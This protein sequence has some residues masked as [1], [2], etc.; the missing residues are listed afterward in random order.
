MT[1]REQ[2]EELERKTLSSFATLA[3]ETKG[4]V[5]PDEPCPI[6]TDFQRDRD[7]IIHCKSFRRLKHKTQV[8]LS[9]EGDHYRTRL[10]HTLEVSQIARTSARALRLNE[11][12]TEAISLGHD[13]GHTPFGHAGEQVLDEI[14]PHGY[15]HSA[16]SVRV[17]ERLENDGRGLNLTW[18]V[19]NGIACHSSGK[20]AETLEG[21][22]VRYADK[23]AYMNHDIEDAVRAGVLREDDIPWDLKYLLGRTKSD[24][25]TT[26]ITAII[27]NS[28]DNIRLGQE[29]Q[30]AYNKLNRF[31]F[32]AVYTN[33]SAKG[34]EGKAQTL[35]RYLYRY[36]AS[37]P[38]KMPEEYQKIAQQ[39]DLDR[40]VCDYISG[41]TDRYAVAV[42]EELMIPRAW[43]I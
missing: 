11:D 2:T 9:P 34:E 42:Y 23:I 22:I 4:R 39:E 20:E 36:F 19:K 1:I 16:Q 31:L 8:F 32:D 6:R 24:R 15:R 38:E 33:P 17:V 13:L 26:F 21:R 7:R 43:G 35:L 40:A 18:E 5:R 30:D 28:S 14:C 3:S 29:M 37:S 12:L 10:T 41:M 27:E 25:I